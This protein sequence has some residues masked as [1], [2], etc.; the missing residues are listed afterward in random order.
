[1]ALVLTLRHGDFVYIGPDIALTLGAKKG[2][3]FRLVIEAPREVQITTS[4]YDRKQQR[5]LK[6]ELK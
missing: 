5:K 1:M 2:R 4:A 3:H 6:E